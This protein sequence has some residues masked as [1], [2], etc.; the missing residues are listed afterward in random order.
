[1]PTL[2]EIGH[3]SKTVVVGEVA[4]WL[5][6]PVLKTG[7]RETVPGVRIPPSPPLLQIAA[8]HAGFSS[9]STRCNQFLKNSTG[10]SSG[11]GISRRGILMARYIKVSLEHHQQRRYQI[12]TA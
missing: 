4:E 9:L 11:L 8:K 10:F 1:M 7:V 5:K 3:C 2:E 12:V 6:A